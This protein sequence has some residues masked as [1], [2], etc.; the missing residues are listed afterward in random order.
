MSSQNNVHWGLGVR[1][2][3]IPRPP[4]SDLISEQISPELVR[5]QRPLFGHVGT[6]VS[7][8]W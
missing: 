6:P 1:I 3:Q 5:I 7:E 2:V 4:F 8:F